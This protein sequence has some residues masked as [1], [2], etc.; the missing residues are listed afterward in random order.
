MGYPG[1]TG[2][3]KAKAR[4][5]G[6]SGTVWMDGNMLG[7]V[8]AVDWNTE[9]EQVAVTIP[10]NWQDE[11]KPGAENRAGTFRFQDVDDRWARMVWGF[12]DARRRGDRAAA[13]EFPEFDIVT[14]IDDVG[15]PFPTRWA[16]RGC[17]L[18]NYGK[19][20]SQDENVLVRDTPF[21]FREDE[22]LDSFEYVR[23]GAQSFHR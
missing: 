7:E 3:L 12:L 21:T 19:G 18:F 6:R 15:A 22:P 11:H 8:V 16:L 14:Q 4:R 1:P 5:L 2:A 9:I 17:N 20:F 23:G 13:A 10:G